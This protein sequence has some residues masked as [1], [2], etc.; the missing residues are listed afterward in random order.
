MLLLEYCLQQNNNVTWLNVL[1][2][3]HVVSFPPQLYDKIATF[4]TD[5]GKY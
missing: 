2:D 1:Q 4:L 5:F 3:F